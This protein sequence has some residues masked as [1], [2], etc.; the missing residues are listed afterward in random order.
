MAVYEAWHHLRDDQHPNIE[1][2]Y[3]FTCGLGS[4]PAAIVPYYPNGTA[5]NYI[6]NGSGV[7]RGMIV[8]IVT[9]ST[10]IAPQ[11]T[12]SSQIRDIA[13]GLEYLHS[14]PGKLYHGGLKAVR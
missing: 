14:H 13:N 8:G 4:L 1:R 6:R 12:L 9:A 11:N 5:L 10:A 3:G 7:C 2:F